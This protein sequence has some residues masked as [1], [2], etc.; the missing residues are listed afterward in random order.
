M[1]NLPEGMIPDRDNQVF[2]DTE[3]KQFYMV[4]WEDGGNR[5]IPTRHYLGDVNINGF[6]SAYSGTSHKKYS[7]PNLNVGL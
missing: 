5:D 3:L 1:K 4:T 7:T 2:F 6:I